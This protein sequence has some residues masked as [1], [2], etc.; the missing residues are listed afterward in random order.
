MNEENRLLKKA[1]WFLMGFICLLAVLNFV[2]GYAAVEA[3]KDSRPADPDASHR[4]MLSRSYLDMIYGER[5]SLSHAEGA[6]PPMEGVM[7]TGDGA[8]IGMAVS[9]DE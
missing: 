8:T 3:G 2:M 7:Q 1:V 6:P 5:R 4:R 9:V